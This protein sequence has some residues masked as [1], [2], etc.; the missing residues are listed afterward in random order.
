MARS[1]VHAVHAG[2]VLA[3]N[4]TAVA[5]G[6]RLRAYRP[7]KASLYLLASGDRRAIASWGGFS[8]EGRWVWR[9]KDAIDRRFIARQQVRVD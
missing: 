1:G 8:A 7:K 4:L 2:P 9:W 3:H 6:E 5:S